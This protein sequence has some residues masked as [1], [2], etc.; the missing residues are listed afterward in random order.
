LVVK[1]LIVDDSPTP[2]LILRRALEGL[3]H[4]CVVAEDGNQA[5]EKFRSLVPDVIIS[6]WMMPGM[7]G[8]ELCRQ[9]RSDPSAPYTYFI[10]LT[11]L[12]DRASVVKG[13]EAGADDHLAKSFDRSELETRLIAAERVA[14]LH[15]RLAAQQ[16]ELER[17]NSILREDSRRDH[18]TGLGNRMR[19]D[20]DLAILSS[21]AE[22]YGHGFC[23]VLFDIDRFKAYND[24]AGHLA[25]DEVL[26][27]VAAALANQ[28]RSGDSVY[29]YGGEELLAVLPEQDLEGA[30]VAAERM[31]HEV[32]GLAIAHP[33]IG[34]PPGLV[35]VSG[36]VACFSPE[37]VG[38]VEHLLKR[39]DEA[40]Y[41]A[42]NGGRNR[43]EVAAARE[44]V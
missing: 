3:G 9:V 35:T 13:M 31:R 41:R 33:G 5:L 18:L 36:G 42:K 21:R 25:G 8:D 17:L 29:R 28:A 11:S 1:I 27:S 10:L 26:R 22:R 38:D 43:I 39:A 2:R 44:R 24:S 40:L 23:V 30:T 15:G 19:Q 16:T 4:E 37:D 34:P 32:E 14:A 20:E 6:D 7:D 12:D